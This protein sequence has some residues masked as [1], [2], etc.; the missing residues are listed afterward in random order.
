VGG[1][2]V[3]LDAYR[4]TGHELDSALDGGAGSGATAKSMLRYLSGDVYAFEPFPGNH[5]F[6]ADAD[7]RIHLIPRALADGP[8]ICVK[9]DRL[10][11][12]E[13][14]LEVLS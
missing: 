9:K 12:F 10:E 7:P 14:A 3:L 6:F 8:G 4:K 2:Q 13:R 11:E 1:F 5:R